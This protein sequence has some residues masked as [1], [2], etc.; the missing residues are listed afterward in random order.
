MTATILTKNLNTQVSLPE[1]MTQ[2]KRCWQLAI[3]GFLV[4]IKNLL[5]ALELWWVFIPLQ[6]QNFLNIYLLYK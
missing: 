5:T 2:K 1:K 6:V 3:T 4:K